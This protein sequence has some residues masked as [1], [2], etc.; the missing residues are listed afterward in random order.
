MRSL[1]MVFLCVCV[2]ACGRQEPVQKDF[3]LFP[4][5]TPELRAL[6]NKHADTY[7]VPRLL[8]HKVV[9][10]ES[11]YRPRARNG[12]YYGM[13]QILPATARGMGFQGQNEDL[14]D[15]D[16]NLTWAVKYLR[17]AW[18]VSDGDMDEAVMWYARGYYYEARN[19]CLLVETSLLNRE[20]AKHCKA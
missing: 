10:R 14:L 16:V 4:N 17:G 18:L 1:W 5:E 8:V 2:V 6:I 9:Q 12:P 13:M 11:D 15:P 19:R 20:I 7:E 3:P